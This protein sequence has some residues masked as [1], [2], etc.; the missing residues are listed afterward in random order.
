MKDEARV[1][2]EPLL[3]LGMLVGGVVVE[4]DMNGRTPSTGSQSPKRHAKSF[5]IRS[6]ACGLFFMIRFTMSEG[7]RYRHKGLISSVA[8]R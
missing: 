5:W 7:L 6:F 2:G 3:D 4:D 8:S 1:P